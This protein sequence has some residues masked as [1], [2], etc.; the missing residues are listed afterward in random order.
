MLTEAQA[1]ALVE[2]ALP[3]VP[4]KAWAQYG[5][6]YLFRVQYPDLEEADFD[7]FFS[8]DTKTSEVKDF[9]VI[10]DGNISDIAALDWKEV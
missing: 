4:I 7:P 2:K 10:T 9:S 5:D 8:V 3:G 6:L 1:Q